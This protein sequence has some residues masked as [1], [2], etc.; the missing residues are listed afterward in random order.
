[1]LMLPY[2][3]QFRPPT[4]IANRRSEKNDCPQSV[5]PRKVVDDVSENGPWYQAERA[6]SSIIFSAEK[7]SRCIIEGATVL[8]RAFSIQAVFPVKARFSQTM[9]ER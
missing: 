4:Y 7:G 5:P 8:E 9:T 1:M 6:A 2:N 3:V